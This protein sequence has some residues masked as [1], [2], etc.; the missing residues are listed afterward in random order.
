MKWQN[1][2][3]GM[4]RRQSQLEKKARKNVA[5]IQKLLVDVKLAAPQPDWFVKSQEP[6]PTRSIISDILSLRDLRKDHNS[7][8]SLP[9]RS[10]SNYGT[11]ASSSIHTE[12]ELYLE[13][14]W[15]P[16]TP[17][18]HLAP[19]VVKHVQ[20]SL[21]T[22]T[23]IEES[24]VDLHRNVYGTSE[25]Q[26]KMASLEW[27]T[28]RYPILLQRDKFT[29][30]KAVTTIGKAWRAFL[31]R[32]AFTEI[33]KIVRAKNIAA[34]RI[35]QMYRKI[36]LAR[37][38]KTEVGKVKAEI[39]EIFVQTAME[40]IMKRFEEKA[41][42]EAK[43]L[44]KIKEEK[45]AQRAIERRRK[46]E[47]WLEKERLRIAAE[48]QQKR[49]DRSS[50]KIQKCWRCFRFYVTIRKK[51]R[52]K[53]KRRAAAIM[54]Q[55]HFRAKRIQRR[56]SEIYS[57]LKTIRMKRI[58]REAAICIQQAFM[59]YRGKKWAHRTLYGIYI[60][61]LTRADYEIPAPNRLHRWVFADDPDYVNPAL[62]RR[63][64]T[65]FF[66]HNPHRR[67]NKAIR[68]KKLLRSRIELAHVCHMTG[69]LCSAREEW[70]K[71][72]N[73]RIGNA[74]PTQRSVAYISQLILVLH[75][76]GL[77]EEA[78]PWIA[79]CDQI[80]KQIEHQKKWHEFSS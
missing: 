46:R 63:L 39:V 3:Y 21:G 2:A 17:I 55:K 11:A 20:K 23:R 64:F 70:L 74:K 25:T 66:V 31:A 61:N 51:V 48:D 77:Y 36:R 44:K 9:P 42:I 22:N 38:T 35:Q 56:N 73:D 76:S 75:A 45:W 41:K 59:H 68:S 8:S 18:Q 10:R 52:D 67:T 62:K 72:V 5:K 58:K 49:M 80:V 26:S 79:A 30:A 33:L 50:K 19:D 43:R 47:L 29:E 60:R 7:M 57:H 28:Y 71:I 6:I 16:R 32:R 13:R 27:F 69:R 65:E 1:N 15:Q 24:L 14:D 54:I 37:L 4:E 40:N 78:E 12:H 53:M 34:I